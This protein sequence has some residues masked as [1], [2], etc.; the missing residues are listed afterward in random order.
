MINFHSSNCKNLAA[1]APQKNV[2]SQ[3]I[4]NNFVARSETVSEC[5]VKNSRQKVLSLE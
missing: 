3:N 1:Q 2:I 5:A 4:R